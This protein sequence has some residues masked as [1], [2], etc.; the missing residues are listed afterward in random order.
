MRD[1]SHLFAV[2]VLTAYR[3][4]IVIVF[5]NNDK[6][7][8]RFAIT[9]DQAERGKRFVYSITED[10]PAMILSHNKLQVGAVLVSVTIL[11]RPQWSRTLFR[12]NYLL[13]LRETMLV[14][15]QQMAV[16]VRCIYF[17]SA[18]HNYKKCHRIPGLVGWRCLLSRLTHMDCPILMDTKWDRQYKTS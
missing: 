5:E 12:I 1:G 7:G 4:T 10:S 14:I 17:P 3:R 6:L 15:K 2:W 18:M 13:T 16:L 8:I 11:H 9:G